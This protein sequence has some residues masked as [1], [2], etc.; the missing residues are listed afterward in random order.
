MIFIS[1]LILFDW[2]GG[3]EKGKGAGRIDPPPTPIE[4]MSKQRLQPTVLA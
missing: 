4:Y 2:K 1:D 3:C